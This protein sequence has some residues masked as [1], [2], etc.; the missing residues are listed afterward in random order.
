MK[1]QFKFGFLILL[2]VFLCGKAGAQWVQTGPVGGWIEDLKASGNTLYAASYGG[3]L[4][5]TDNG[6]GWTHS[7]WG[8]MDGD[9][10]AVA[11]TSTKVYAGTYWSGIYMRDL[12]GL[13]WIPTTLDNQSISCLTTIGD[14]V[15]AGTYSTGV[16]LST[17][18]GTTWAQV[19]NGLTALQVECFATKGTDIYVDVEGGSIFRST[20][21]RTN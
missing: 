9:V 2:L 18:N 19:N 5:S 6:M 21:Y 15:F 7:N 12:Y 16:W 14:Y 13:I 10:T 20:D 4:V 8:F 1:K 11:V 3:I 17:D